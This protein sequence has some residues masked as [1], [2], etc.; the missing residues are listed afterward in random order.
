MLP[1]KYLL[2][3][4]I[5]EPM[6][7]NHI[8]F[9][10]YEVQLNFPSLHLPMDSSVNEWVKERL[11]RKNFESLFS[12]RYIIKGD[13]TWEFN[14]LYP[15]RSA[16]LKKLVLY[17]VTGLSCLAFFRMLCFFYYY[18]YYYLSWLCKLIVSLV[19]KMH[20]YFVVM[21][22][23]ARHIKSFI[24]LLFICGFLLFCKWM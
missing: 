5:Y 8:S 20:Y 21:R 14:F 16:P 18:Y 24:L 6:P 1:L 7:H 3:I 23:W 22:V 10:L 11:E 13:P 17:V 15:P 19:K 12:S 4:A 9:S 2:F